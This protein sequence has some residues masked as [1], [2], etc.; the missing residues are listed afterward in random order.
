MVHLD[1]VFLE[2]KSMQTDS[3][4]LTNLF[5]NHYSL[6]VQLSESEMKIN[7]QIYIKHTNSN[8]LKKSL[9]E[10]H[11]IWYCQSRNTNYS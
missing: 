9:V 6:V 3:H 7:A 11:G 2:T 4:K 10:Q 8:K 1:T 5:I